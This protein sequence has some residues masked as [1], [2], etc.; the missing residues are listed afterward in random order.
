VGRP[1][2]ELQWQADVGRMRP[3]M[4]SGFS[5]LPGFVADRGPICF[6]SGNQPHFFPRAT[7]IYYLFF[8]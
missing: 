5:D 2:G 8:F 3:S 1:E 4:T 6:S 7:P